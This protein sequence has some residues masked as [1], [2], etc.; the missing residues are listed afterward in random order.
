MSR[1]KCKYVSAH[2]AANTFRWLDLTSMLCYRS[3]TGGDTGTVSPFTPTTSHIGHIG[4]RRWWVEEAGI[5]LE[6][7]PLQY[8]TPPAVPMVPLW[9]QAPTPAPDLKFDGG[10]D[11]W[12]LLRT[13]CTRALQGVIRVLMFGA[14][15]YEAH[16]W[17]KV[18]NGATRYRDA[19][20]RHLAEIDL[21]GMASKDAES[22]ELHIYHVACNALFL[23]EL[24]AKEK[25]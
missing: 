14:K 1:V 5:I 21:H 6:E 15:K 2:W 22:G 9:A 19:L 20:D 23:A 24:Q 25:V 3:E 7:V 17:Q 12:S 8:A 16:S 13:G 11:K 18:E 10:K 4:L